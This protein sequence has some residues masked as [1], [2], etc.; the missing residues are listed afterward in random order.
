HVL[1]HD[2]LGAQVPPW[3]TE[4][5]ATLYAGYGP[6]DVALLD[7][8]N[9]LADL[10]RAGRAVPLA[11]L[12][13]ASYAA[14]HPA[15]PQEEMRYYATA[16]ALCLFLKE[17]SCLASFYSAFRDGSRRDGGRD[18]LCRVAGVEAGVLAWAFD[19]W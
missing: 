5:L 18:V 3:L 13:G 17:R 2:D 14:F 9:A 15:A 19:R 10:R 8:S 16:E 7:P 11:D 1:V 6:D 12:L 4:G